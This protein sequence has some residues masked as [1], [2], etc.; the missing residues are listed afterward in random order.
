MEAEAK[1]TTGGSDAFSIHR[2]LRWCL[3][4]MR[5]SG[6][7]RSYFVNFVPAERRFRPMTFGLLHSSSSTTR[8]CLPVTST[9][10][11]CPS[12]ISFD[13]RGQVLRA[14]VRL[15][16]LCQRS[17]VDK[18]RRADECGDGEHGWAVEPVDFAQ[19]D[20]VANFDVIDPHERLSLEDASRG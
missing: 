8:R 18:P 20:G 6:P 9:F 15:D 13:V 3:R 7:T 12:S 2:E 5:R 14:L 16:A 11:T 1:T 10:A 4:P 19:V 17:L